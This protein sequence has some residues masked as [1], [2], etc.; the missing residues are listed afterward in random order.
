MEEVIIKKPRV[1]WKLSEGGKSLGVPVLIIVLS[2]TA[3]SWRLSSTS[4]NFQSFESPSPT[5]DSNDSVHDLRIVM[6][7]GRRRTNT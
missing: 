3:L 1:Y 7:D 5:E 4:G 6:S 2:M